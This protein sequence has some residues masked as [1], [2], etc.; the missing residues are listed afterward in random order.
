VLML[1]RLSS[2]VDD[3]SLLGKSLSKATPSYSQSPMNHANDREH[4]NYH[5]RAQRPRDQDVVPW[6]SVN[7][8]PTWGVY[9]ISE[10]FHRAERVWAYP[11]EGPRQPRGVFEDLAERPEQHVRWETGGHRGSRHHHHHRHHRRHGHHH[12]RS[13]SHR[14]KKRH[15][16]AAGRFCP[17]VSRVVLGEDIY[18]RRQ[19]ILSQKTTLG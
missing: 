17:C 14:H 10:S 3:R 16:S 5:R 9:G 8:V 7:Q 15:K 12:S 18:P 11:S 2:Q 1:V 13:R 6:Q 4:W 19:R